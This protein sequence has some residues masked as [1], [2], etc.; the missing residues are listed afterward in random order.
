MQGKTIAVTGASRGIGAAIAL[1]LA[2]RGFTVAC[3]T[4]KGAGAEAAGVP[5]ERVIDVQCDVT[6]EASV[7]RAFSETV[8]RAGGLHGLVNNAGI[9]IDAPSHEMSTD[10]YEQVMATNATAV[11]AA[12]REAYPHLVRAG[13]GV[14][15][16]IGSFFDRIGVKRNLAY[17]ASKAAVGA[18]TRC[19]A[20][21]W[22]GKGVRVL[23]V[24]P[25][26]I[27]TDL[28]RDTLASGPLRDFLA[29]RI[30]GGRTGSTRDVARLVAAIFSEDIPFLTGETIYLDGG[31]GI[32]H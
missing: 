16:N 27:E 17:C 8:T 20:V 6:D 2:Q 9:H 31:Q 15:V 1:E 18:I 13:G 30:P 4:R 22:A 5:A 21:E 7:K 25:G 12:C 3:L 24:A 23:D 11:F 32:A 26:Y 28:N 10:T 14:I 29:K 19:L